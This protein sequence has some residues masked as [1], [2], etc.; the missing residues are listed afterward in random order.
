MHVAASVQPDLMQRLRILYT[1]LGLD[2][3]LSARD[4]LQ[5]LITL[6][7]FHGV[8]LQLCQPY[9]HTMTPAPNPTWEDFAISCVLMDP[10]TPHDVHHPRANDRS[11]PS[12]V[13]TVGQVAPACA[14]LGVG[15]GGVGGGGCTK[16]GLV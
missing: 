14:A 13:R 7:A 2:G 5:R 4:R 15:G 16:F 12:L 9:A 10:R 8:H 3:D 6:L 1:T 11:A